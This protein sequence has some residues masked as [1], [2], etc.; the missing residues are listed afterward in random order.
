MNS[1]RKDASEDKRI[2]GNGNVGIGTTS[3]GRGLSIDKSNQY[4]AL[5]IIKN[6]TTNQIVYLGTGSSA[7]TDDPILQ[8]KHNG[9]ENIFQAQQYQVQHQLQQKIIVAQQ[10]LLMVYQLK[11]EEIAQVVKHLKLEMIQVILI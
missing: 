5:E 4:A 2:D 1:Q 10:Q 9:T 6:N 7:G 3:P 11:V 8:M